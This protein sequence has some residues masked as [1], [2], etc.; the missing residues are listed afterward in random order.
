MVRSNPRP[1]V[2]SADSCGAVG[3]DRWGTACGTRL[4]LA[5]LRVPPGHGRTLRSR[6]HQNQG[7]LLFRAA[8]SVRGGECEQA[9]ADRGEPQ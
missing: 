8:A 2:P 6:P 9:Y 5:R 3:H 4:S 7:R 1:L